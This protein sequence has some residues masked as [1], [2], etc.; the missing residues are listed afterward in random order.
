VP[1]D[2]RKITSGQPLDK[3]VLPR[4]IFT[5]LPAKGQGLGYLRDV[6]PDQQEKP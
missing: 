4:D 5:A 1:L 2:F 3:L 6:P